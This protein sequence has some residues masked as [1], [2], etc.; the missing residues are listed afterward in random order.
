MTA[1]GRITVNINESTARVFD[2]AET[3]GMSKTE[4]VR[5]GVALLGLYQ[6]GRLYYQPSRGEE[7]ERIRIL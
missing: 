3:D 4:A 6:S 5:V 1:A 7:M 2:V